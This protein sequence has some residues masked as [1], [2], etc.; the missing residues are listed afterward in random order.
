MSPT[1]R[2]AGSLSLKLTGMPDADMDRFARDL[3]DTSPGIRFRLALTEAG[4][5]VRMVRQL[6]QQYGPL[7]DQGST[8]Y[9]RLQTWR[10]QYIKATEVGSIA[11]GQLWEAHRWPTD[12]GRAEAYEYKPKDPA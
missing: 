10:R 9:A 11:L 5:A 4:I 2:Q 7:H 6:I 1:C 8:P 3:K 12:A